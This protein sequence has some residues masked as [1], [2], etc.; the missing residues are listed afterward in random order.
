LL[1]IALLLAGAGLFWPD[2]LGSWKG[3][4]LLPEPPHL[5][6]AGSKLPEVASA[7]GNR[8]QATRPERAPAKLR[9][10]LDLRKGELAFIRIPSAAMRGLL[11]QEGSPFKEL[12]PSLDISLVGSAPR[13]WME[14]RLRKMVE[15]EG[16]V[17]GLVDA[18]D[19]SFA[20]DASGFEFSGS[21]IHFENC[22]RFRLVVKAGED[23][24]EAITR[25]PHGAMVLFK[26]AGENPEGMLLVVGADR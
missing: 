16:T 9:S 1:A 10:L 24:L 11:G 13:E 3:G 20:W 22:A 17:D 6:E 7:P 2:P 8:L 12:E 26:M 4:S 5:D 14:S 21:T 15:A 25:Q 19:D 18:S 23:S